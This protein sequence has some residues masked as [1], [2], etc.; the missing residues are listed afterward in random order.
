[1]A[2][3]LA[4]VW[5]AG[6]HALHLPWF[7]AAIREI[8]DHDVSGAEFDALVKQVDLNGDGKIDCEL[9]NAAALLPAHSVGRAEYSAVAQALWSHRGPT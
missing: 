7:P 8:L 4:L 2:R 6:A 3:E 1:M 5:Y 9:P